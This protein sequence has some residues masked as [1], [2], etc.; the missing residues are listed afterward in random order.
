MF[1]WICCLRHHFCLGRRGFLT[2]LHQQFITIGIFLTGLSGFLLVE[3]VDGGW[4]YTFVLGMFSP[5]VL[6]LTTW[7]FIPESPRWL[8]R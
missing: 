3:Y 2:G 6:W 4:K 5:I 7:A 8:L 1:I